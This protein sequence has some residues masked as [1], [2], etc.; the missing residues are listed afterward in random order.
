MSDKITAALGLTPIEL[1]LPAKFT[2]WRP[3]QEGAI[4]DAVE[5]N[6]RFLAN[7]MPTG[8]GK[9]LWYIAVAKLLDYRVCIL[10]STKALQDQ[11]LHDFSDIGLV[12]IRGRGNYECCLGAGYTCDEG[13]HAKCP[14]KQT[15]RC[16]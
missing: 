13:R 12:D 8:W 1:G 3:G 9:S 2:G 6:R 14:R 10:T 5:C 15:T 16:P 4:L 11:L 7:S